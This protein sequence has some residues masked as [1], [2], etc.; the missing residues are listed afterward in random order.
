MHSSHRQAKILA[1]PEE[2]AWNSTGQARIL[3]YFEYKHLSLTSKI[4]NEERPD[5]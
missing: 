4:Q 2:Y 3:W 5:E 1:T